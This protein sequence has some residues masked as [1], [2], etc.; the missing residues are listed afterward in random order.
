M[1]QYNIYTSI[2]KLHV[3]IYRSTTSYLVRSVKASEIYCTALPS[4]TCS[5][6]DTANV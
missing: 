1:Y 3:P 4:N 2:Y 5:N 6:D